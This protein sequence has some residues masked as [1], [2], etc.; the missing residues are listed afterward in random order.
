MACPITAGTS[1]SWAQSIRRLPG[2][3]ATVEPTMAAYERPNRSL[4]PRSGRSTPRGNSPVGPTPALV[5]GV[6]P[7]ADLKTSAREPP[8]PSHAR[9]FAARQCGRG[10]VPRDGRR[11]RV[12]AQRVEPV[13]RQVGHF[14]GA[15]ESRRWSGRRRRPIVSDMFLVPVRSSV[16]PL[17]PSTATSS[18]PSAHR[19]RSASPRG[20]SRWTIT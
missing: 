20:S 5:P 1:G 17:A 12:S 19:I 9:Q 18:A 4:A 6:W 2:Q 14:V 13:Q 10:A 16:S 11:A 8:I 7:G 3:S 15:P